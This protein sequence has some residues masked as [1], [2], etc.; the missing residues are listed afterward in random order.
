MLAQGAENDV[1]MKM[2]IEALEGLAAL[3]AELRDLTLRFNQEQKALTDRVKDV[4]GDGRFELFKST[5]MFD[6]PV[7]RKQHG[8]T[9]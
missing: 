7:H 8:F 5:Q 2:Q 6:G 1:T 9:A 4:A 3:D